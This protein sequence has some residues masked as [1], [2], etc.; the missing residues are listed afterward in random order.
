[1][2]QTSSGNTDVPTD[3]YMARP[4]LPCP[5]RPPQLMLRPYLANGL[6]L[7]VVA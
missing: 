4:R 7:R 1:M 3:S 5:P 2:T 6:T